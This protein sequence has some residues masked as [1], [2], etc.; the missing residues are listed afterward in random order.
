[1]PRPCS[2]CEHPKRL[3]IEKAIFLED[4]LRNIAKRFSTNITSLSRHRKDHL[5][6]KAVQAVHE[7]KIKREGSL[8]TNLGTWDSR[9]D[10]LYQ[11]AV[12]HHE[13][14]KENDPKLSLYALRTAAYIAREGRGLAELIGE[15]NQEI[16]RKPDV[17]VNV[18]HAD[19]VVANVMQK[20]E[21]QAERL[22]PSESQGDSP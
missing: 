4:P 2:I 21:V 15:A 17:T 18:L 1:M 8:L 22:K 6:D 3:Q 5:P 12:A 9:V 7:T 10:Y 19:A 20:I 13:A 11:E 14:N 16:D